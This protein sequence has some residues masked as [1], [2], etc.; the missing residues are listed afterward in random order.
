MANY[1]V[2]IILSPFFWVMPKVKSLVIAL[3]SRFEDGLFFCCAVNKNIDQ[4]I[5]WRIY[6]I[7]VITKQIIHSMFNI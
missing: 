1:I 5:F 4:R 2:F 6:A 3:S 7:F